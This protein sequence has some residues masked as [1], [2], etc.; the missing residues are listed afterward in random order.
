[1]R[2]MYFAVLPRFYNASDPVS[3]R[4]LLA[5]HPVQR[6]SWRGEQICGEEPVVRIE[7]VMKI[8]GRNKRHIKSAI[9]WSRGGKYSNLLAYWN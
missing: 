2:A 8:R 4:P 9:V 3:N 7:N 6:P 5:A 1:M